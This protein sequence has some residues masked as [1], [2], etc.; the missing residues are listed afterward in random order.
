MQSKE[1]IIGM[2]DDMKMSTYYSMNGAKPGPWKAAPT[3][4]D[5]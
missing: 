1:V 5:Q 2:L 3:L 4:F